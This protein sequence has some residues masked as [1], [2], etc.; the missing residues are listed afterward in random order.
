VKKSGKD[1]EDLRKIL[2][3]LATHDNDK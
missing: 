1:H 2:F 3:P